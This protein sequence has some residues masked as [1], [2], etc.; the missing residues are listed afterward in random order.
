MP[1]YCV[2]SVP[3]SR[4]LTPTAVVAIMKDDAVA[5]SGVGLFAQSKAPPLPPPLPPGAECTF[6]VNGDEYCIMP[7]I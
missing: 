6:G 3:V 7:V 5:S 4:S 1:Q 2:N